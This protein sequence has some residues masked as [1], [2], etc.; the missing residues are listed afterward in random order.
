MGIPIELIRIGDTS[1][2]QSAN[3]ISTGAS[4]GSDVNG[5]AVIDACKTIKERMEPYRKE[6]RSW[7]E[8]VGAA[9]MDRYRNG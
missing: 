5:A 4:I 3:A 8:A 7:S 2:A 9:L 1:T 6:G